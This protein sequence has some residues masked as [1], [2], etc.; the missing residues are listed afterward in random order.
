[1]RRDR[2][3]RLADVLVDAVVDRVVGHDQADVGV[4]L[5]Q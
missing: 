3:D 5:V 1:M 4:P 2:R